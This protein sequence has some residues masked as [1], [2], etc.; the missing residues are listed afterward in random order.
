MARKKKSKKKRTSDAVDIL[1]R[2]Y[3]RGDAEM[4]KLVSEEY[5][6]SQVAR[7]L[8]DLRKKVGLTQQ[9]LADL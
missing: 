8:Y 6:N 5:A 9:Q 7:K 2:R 3:V 4:E 1:E